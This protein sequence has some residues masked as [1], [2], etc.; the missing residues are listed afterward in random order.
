MAAPFPW[1]SFPVFPALFLLGLVGAT[2]PPAAARIPVAV[3]GAWVE[4]QDSLYSAGLAQDL[5]QALAEDTAL[6]V[7]DLRARHGRRLDSVQAAVGL[8]KAPE[9]LSALSGGQVRWGLAVACRAERREDD[10]GDF[11]CLPTLLSMKDARRVPLDTLRFLPEAAG[12]RKQVGQG[13]AL[14]FAS[15]FRPARAPAPA[16]LKLSA[17]A[18]PA[19]VVRD[20]EILRRGSIAEVPL[21]ATLVLGDAPGPVV[22]AGES[23]H[24]ILYPGSAYTFLL[25]RLVRLHSGALGLLRNADSGSVAWRSEAEAAGDSAGLGGLVLAASR[26][27][28]DSLWRR[29]ALRESTVVI[30]SAC[31]IHGMPE[32]ALLRE[33]GG[34]TTL[35]VV[36]GGM[37]IH[38]LLGSQPPAAVGP[39]RTC[40]TRGFALRL[41]PLGAARGDRILREF[42][43]L[44]PG[45]G[46][47]G[48]A[49]FLPG[50]LFAAGASLRTPQRSIQAFIAGEFREM[51]MDVGVLSSERDGWS[52][53][54][55]FRSGA[56]ESGCYLCSPDR[57]G[58]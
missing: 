44:D 50:K 29:L 18:N 35:E 40:Q 13:L 19:L 38:P 1:H 11:L 49:S 25:P 41:E 28:A 39:M 2:V 23:V 27:G 36:R 48:L 7:Y 32:A 14:R 37:R 3:L 34:A 54:G 51:D 4:G 57:I 52:E 15:H 17:P 5:G 10:G 31:V 24:F 30:T 21:G 53:P 45:R 42:E 46:G 9:L 12:K 47:R 22:L 56:Q 43:R 16:V 26:D 20:L 55:T 58:P 6:L 8:D 33:A